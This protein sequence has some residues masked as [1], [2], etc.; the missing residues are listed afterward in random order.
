MH[1]QDITRLIEKTK[2]DLVWLDEHIKEVEKWHPSEMPEGLD[3]VQQHL[4][5]L[6]ETTH[7]SLVRDRDMCQRRLARLLEMLSGS[8]VLEVA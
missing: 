4:W 2:S 7:Q 1:Q 6:G 8:P 5:H 3:W